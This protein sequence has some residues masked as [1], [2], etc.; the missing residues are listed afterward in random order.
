MEEVL[1]EPFDRN[2]GIHPRNVDRTLAPTGAT[3]ATGEQ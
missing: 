1:I 2:I 3:V